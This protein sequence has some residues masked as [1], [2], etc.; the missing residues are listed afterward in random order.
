MDKVKAMDAMYPANTAMGHEMELGDSWSL[1]SWIEGLEEIPNKEELL[2]LTDWEEPSG[3]EVRSTGYDPSPVVNS[4][5]TASGIQ[6]TRAE[7]SRTGY[8]IVLTL[9]VWLS[10][11]LRLRYANR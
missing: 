7:R 4:Q 5:A 11:R 3:G 1:R 9:G 10:T 2:W 6:P 8:I